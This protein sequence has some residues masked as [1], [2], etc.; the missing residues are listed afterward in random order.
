MAD[1]L[2][3]RSRAARLMST[4]WDDEDFN[5][6]FV[7][8]GDWAK[9]GQ[10]LTQSAAADQRLL[11]VQET[12]SV[13]IFDF[14]QTTSEEWREVMFYM[15]SMS[16]LAIDFATRFGAAPSG[17]NILSHAAPFPQLNEYIETGENNIYFLNEFELHV[18]EKYWQGPA[19]PFSDPTTL[20]YSVVDHSEVLGGVTSEMFDVV[21]V[22]HHRYHGTSYEFIDALI[23][24]VKPGG[25][26]LSRNMA[27]RN[28]SYYQPDFIHAY[29]EHDYSRHIA[30]HPDMVSRHIS[31][32]NG[33][34]VAFKN[35]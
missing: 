33:Y 11:A 34:V 16:M 1:R 8:L 18:S 5:D 14:L 35:R 21:H 3:L 24:S 28:F 12:E 22:P 9:V 10:E 17:L 30:D 32:G 6:F 31:W 27:P 15:A 13:A 20:K 25:M 26:L 23:D 4:G 7:Q 2:T 29:P 19:S